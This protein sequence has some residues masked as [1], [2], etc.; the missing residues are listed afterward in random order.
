LIK[1]HATSLAQEGKPLTVPGEPTK[2][3]VRSSVDKLP[4]AIK[5]KESPV[6]DSKDEVIQEVKTDVRTTDN[7]ASRTGV[8][9]ID[10]R[11]GNSPIL[12]SHETLSPVQS[13]ILSTVSLERK[14]E[15]ILSSLSLL[16]LKTDKITLENKLNGNL[17]ACIPLL[18][19]DPEASISESAKDMQISDVT[20]FLTNLRDRNDVLKKRLEKLELEN[21]ELVSKLNSDEFVPFK[22]FEERLKI[23]QSQVDNLKETK[24]ASFKQIL[25]LQSVSPRLAFNDK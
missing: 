16:H 10:S 12:K 20:R 19:C 13:N 9:P 23:L 11:A 24:S 21:L 8:N 14:I 17:N 7:A 25:N 18:T 15:D 4:D 1:V 5:T 3:A 22:H 2:L 6:I